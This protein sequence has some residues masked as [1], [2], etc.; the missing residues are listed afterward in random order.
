MESSSV[1]VERLGL[2]AASAFGVQL[3]LRI[4]PGRVIG[5]LGAALAVCLRGTAQRFA[6]LLRN[7]QVALG[8]GNRRVVTGFGTILD[9]IRSEE[10]TSELQSRENLVCR[11]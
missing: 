6:T 3:T 1:V 11:L 10:H 9:R 7:I 2:V 8:F 5:I 4:L